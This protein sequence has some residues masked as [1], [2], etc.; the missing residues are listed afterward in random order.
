MRPDTSRT[1]QGVAINLLTNVMAE[2]RTA[3]GQQTVGIAATLAMWVAEEAERGADRLVIEN[4]ATREILGDGLEIAGS[5][6]ESV[7]AAIAT[8]VAPDFKI[9]SLQAENDS[10]RRGLIALHAAVEANGSAAAQAM[11]ERIWAELIESTRRRQF[12]VRIG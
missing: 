11:N 1:L 6:A 8:P 9:S 7:R 4:R 10:L 3:F 12:Q 5:E 2:T